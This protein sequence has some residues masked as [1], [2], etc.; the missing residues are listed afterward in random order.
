M[1]RWYQRAAKCYVYLWDVHVPD[2]VSDVQSF[3]ITWQEAFRRSRWFNRGWTLQELIAPAT[4]EFFSKGG[5]QLGTKISLE[6]EIY[7]IT[8][9]PITAL[10]GQRLA[11]FSFDERMS[12]AANRKTTIKEDK[13]YCLLGIF[14]V[15]M[16]LIYGEGEDHALSRLNDEIQR[17]AGRAEWRKKG[18]L[19]DLSG[20]SSSG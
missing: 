19:Q 20:M 2:E 8:K 16:P 11:E 18:H 12:W 15:F 13:I 17:G 7:D 4:V 9:I 6:Q 10:R 5:T 1:Y 14:E 3:R